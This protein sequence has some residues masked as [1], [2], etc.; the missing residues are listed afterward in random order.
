MQRML[1]SS[2]SLNCAMAVSRTTVPATR[3]I[4]LK[5]LYSSLLLSE[6]AATYAPLIA[7]PSRIRALSASRRM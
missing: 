2:I 5:R 1:S 6:S 4:S 7:G 3:G